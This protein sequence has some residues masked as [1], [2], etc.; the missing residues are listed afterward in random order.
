MKID[1][2]ELLETGENVMGFLTRLAVNHLKLVGAEKKQ[3]FQIWPP[4]K[5]TFGFSRFHHVSCEIS[6]KFFGSGC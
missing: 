6:N 4:Q 2:Q 5:K 1:G 3:I